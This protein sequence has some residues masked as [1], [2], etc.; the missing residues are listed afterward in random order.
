MVQTT[1]NNSLDLYLYFPNI[2]HRFLYVDFV[3]VFVFVYVIMS[4]SIVAMLFPWFDRLQYIE[5]CIYILPKI[6]KNVFILI[7]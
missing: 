5:K 7:L 2:Y 3:V 1:K 6:K 4:F